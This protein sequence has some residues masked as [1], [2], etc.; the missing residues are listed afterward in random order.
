MDAPWWK[1]AVI[2]QIYP[3]SFADWS[4]DGIGDLA[5]I[6][7]HL[8]H[9][10]W[11]GVDGLWLSP[12]YPSPMADFG[13]DVAN[14]TDIDPVFGSLEGFDDL[15]AV[16][17]RRALR[18]LLDWVPNHTSD[19]HPWFMASR[20]SLNNPYRDWYI[21]RDRPNNWRRA[22]DDGPAWTRDQRTGQYYLH[23]FL[24]QQPDLNWGNPSVR[25]AMHETLRFWLDR[26]VDGF[27]ADVV[28]LIGKDPA[29]PDDPEPLSSVSRV[30]FH[31]DPRTHDWLREIRTV[32]DGY[33][34][35]RAMV[36]EINLRDPAAVAAHTGVD[37]LHLAFNFNLLWA[38]WDAAAFR[39]AIAT[40]E[41]ATGGPNGWPAW[42]L[43]N[44][45]TPRHRTRYGGSEA[46]ARAAAVV[47]LTL[48]GTPFLYAGEELGL[49][50]AHIPDDAVVDPGGRDPCRAPIPWDDGDRHGWAGDPWLPWPPE[51]GTRNAAA[52]RADTGSTANLY[53][54]LLA[55]RRADE[56]L[57]LGALELLDVHSDVL[58]YDRVGPDTRRRVLVNFSAH[59]VRVDA[60]AWQ[61]GV[62]TDRA[63]E[64]ARFDGALDPSAA[65]VLLPAG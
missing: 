19:R 61:V 39:E 18:V 31:T 53:R 1:R 63:R 15:L 30:G 64:G 28:H 65:V 2:Y 49:E 46:R 9:L 42:V 60:G 47:L 13:Y 23:L 8:D 12:I 32:L 50:D 45:D 35:D 21:W 34:G 51:P 36:G 10:T 3:R 40:V 57:Q 29:L 7:E 4:G 44:H 26:G 22:F 5:G 17:H 33:D 48:R 14:Y 43:S 11:L 56:T 6:R 24:P 52:Q 25:E 20:G 41:A 59:P 38:P 62:A 54:R 58:A 37:Q 16:S 55:R 27:R